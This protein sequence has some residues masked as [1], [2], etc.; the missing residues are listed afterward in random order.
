MNLF[1]DLDETLVSSWICNEK[2]FEIEESGWIGDSLFIN[3]YDIASFRRPCALDI[4]D[5]CRS[6]ADN[7]FI[8]TT[9][10]IGYAEIVIDR[11]GFAFKEPE[12]F[13]RDSFN[14]DRFTK[15]PEENFLIDNLTYWDFIRQRNHNKVAFLGAP[16]EENF[17]HIPEFRFYHEFD[18]E[19]DL[20]KGI[21]EQIKKWK[22]IF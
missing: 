17:F 21:E 14:D 3:G 22:N 13:H 2:S 4:I 9:A 6:E 19:K 12:I 20:V 11:F 15:C 10:E 1:I 18:L 7:V 5:L 8:L 16:K